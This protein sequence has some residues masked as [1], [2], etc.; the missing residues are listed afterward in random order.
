MSARSW[1]TVQPATNPGRLYAPQLAYWSVE[2]K[3]LLYGGRKADST[4]S[5]EMWTYDGETWERLCSD[6]PP[7][8]RLG[9]SLVLDET[10]D[11]IVLFGGQ[12]GSGLSNDLWEFEGGAW[13]EVTPTGTPPSPRLGAFMAFDPVRG[14]TVLFGGLEQGDTRV[15]DLFEYDGSAWYALTPDPRPLARK[16]YGSSA[17]FVDADALAVDMRNRV[18]I[19][20][21]DVAGGT[22][23]DECWAWDG[24]DWTRTCTACTGTARGGAVLGY[25]P[26]YGRLVMANGWTGTAS[27][28][29]TVEHDA[30]SWVKTSSLPTARD[31]SG[32]AYDPAR[33]RFVVYGGNAPSCA[34]A[35]DETLEYVV[36]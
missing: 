7:G 15:D 32:I 6:C 3:V 5:A 28:A 17:A 19:C 9:H 27:I 18:V 13:H 14:R 25:D 12:T 8:P 36:R 4:L 11:V 1:I 31:N 16:T 10:R 35:C 23:V 22:M 20:G 26:T 30:D 21:G 24:A 33:D 34:G 2:E 29:G